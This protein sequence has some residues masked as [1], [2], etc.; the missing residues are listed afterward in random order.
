MYE[1]TAE[2]SAVECFGKTKLG[3]ET[4]LKQGRSLGVHSTSEESWTTN[5]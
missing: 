2:Y 1:C 3:G 5:N 4:H